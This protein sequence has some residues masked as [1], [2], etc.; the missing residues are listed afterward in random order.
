MIRIKKPIKVPKILTTRGTAKTRQDRASY[1]ANPTDYR[2]GEKKFNINTKIYGAKS[3]GN[4]L[5][6]A[7]YDKCCYCESKRFLAT[8]YGAVE[9]HRPKGAVQQA[10]GQ[11]KEYPGYNWNICVNQK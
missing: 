4:A 2:S 5:L 7:Q 3:V 10:R 11:K 1:D 8:S 6:R 9:H